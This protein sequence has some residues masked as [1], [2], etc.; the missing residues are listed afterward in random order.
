MLGFL[1]REACPVKSNMVNKVCKDMV[2]KLHPRNFAVYQSSVKVAEFGNFE[3]SVASNE[4]IPMG[5]RAK[6]YVFINHSFA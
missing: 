5:I 2:Y 6:F 4:G 1:R 3:V